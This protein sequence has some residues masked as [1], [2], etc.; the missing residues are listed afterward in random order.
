MYIKEKLQ[1]ICQLIINWDE[2]LHN[3]YN[4][5]YIYI[6]KYDNPD[7]RPSVDSSRLNEGGD[8]T[9]A[10]KSKSNLMANFKAGVYIV[11]FDSFIPQANIDVRIEYR[12]W[13][14]KDA[15]YLVFLMKFSLFFLILFSSVTLFFILISDQQ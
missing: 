4:R 15:F 11:H 14:L 9:P 10:T 2:S 1:N 6:R 3:N 8:S 13:E 12:V 5:G 7:H